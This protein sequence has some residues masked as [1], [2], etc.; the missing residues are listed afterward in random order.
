MHCW[1]YLGTP[2]TSR[3]LVSRFQDVSGHLGVMPKGKDLKRHSSR[4]E[5]EKAI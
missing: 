4:A 2:F 3:M 1:S 5:A